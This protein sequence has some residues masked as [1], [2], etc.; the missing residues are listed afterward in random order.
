MPIGRGHDESIGG[1]EAE[2]PLTAPHNRDFQV[3]V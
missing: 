1:G 3:A 2:S